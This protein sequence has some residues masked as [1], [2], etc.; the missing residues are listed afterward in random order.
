MTRKATFFSKAIFSKQTKYLNDW[1][2]KIIFDEYN[3]DIT[4]Q[5][6]DEILELKI[7]HSKNKKIKEIDD[8]C[9]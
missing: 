2:Y 6:Y 1:D 8:L 5:E 3:I 4:K 7:N 9:K